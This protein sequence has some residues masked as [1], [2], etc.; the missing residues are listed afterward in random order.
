MGYFK[1]L[2][3]AGEKAALSEA[4]E[5]YRRAY[6]PR[7]VPVTLLNHYVRTYAEPYL[8]TQWYLN[9]HP[10]DLKLRDHA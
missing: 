8:A 4:I 7:S 2:L 3:S 5:N 9:P 1:K 10:V 6:V